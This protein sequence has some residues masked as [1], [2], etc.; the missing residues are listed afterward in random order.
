[1]AK[2]KEG[3]Q[4]CILNTGETGVVKQVIDRFFAVVDVNG[5]Y[6]K[7]Q[8]ALL[9]PDWM[10]SRR[11]ESAKG[12]QNLSDNDRS[13]HKPGGLHL[14]FKPREGEEKFSVYLKND[15][16]QKLR[17]HY[18]FFINGTLDTS[19]RQSLAHGDEMLM[20]F[21][22]KDLLNDLPV[23]AVE[24]WPE[25]GGENVAHHFECEIRVKAKQF[26]SEKYILEDGI[27]RRFTFFDE[28]PS[29]KEQQEMIAA[30]KEKG[31][32]G[33]DPKV[34]KVDILG[35]ATFP[36][37]IDLH[38]EKLDLSGEALKKEAI[39]QLQLDAFERYLEQAVRHGLHKVYIVH[40][41]G[42]GILRDQIAER[43]KTNPSVTSFNNDYHHRFG[44]GATE[45]IL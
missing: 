2:I 38:L 45:V 42:K 25:G 44:F 31:G 21:F 34:S 37:F 18:T 9:E 4:V 23:F 14:L 17:L 33:T 19:Q 36:D 10:M 8:V 35:K 27:T 15:S 11:S 29:R 43:L 24:V 13:G 7:I 41:L 3:E 16:G 1:M 40:G 5:D 28:L 39:L 26:F 30:G 12:M 20:Q 22:P 32:A 6:R